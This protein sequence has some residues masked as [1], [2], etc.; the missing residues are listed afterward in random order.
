[1]TELTAGEWPPMAS[2][3]FGQFLVCSEQ[4]SHR[5]LHKGYAAAVRVS[6]G[7]RDCRFFVHT[8][9]PTPRR[10]KKPPIGGLDSA[11]G[12]I[13]PTRQPPL[14]LPSRPAVRCER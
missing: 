12:S 6:S 5:D 3:Y 2:C 7:G 10:M 9:H 1:M 14:V 4:S 13:R 8:P 11:P